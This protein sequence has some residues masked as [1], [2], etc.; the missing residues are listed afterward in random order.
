VSVAISV[1]PAFEMIFC[2]LVKECVFDEQCN[3]IIVLLKCLP[4][5]W[6]R[7]SVYGVVEGF[8]AFFKR[9]SSS[10][11]GCCLFIVQLMC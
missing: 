9:T 5:E 4:Y 7:P 1:L 6:Q 10:L 2:E 8:L 3:K 11:V